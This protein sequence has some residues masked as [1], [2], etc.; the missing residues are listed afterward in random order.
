S[1]APA[2][3]QALDREADFEW[4]R[5][6]G[7]LKWALLEDLG[8]LPDEALRPLVDAGLAAAAAALDE[9]GNWGT[10]HRLHLN[11]IL[12]RAPVIGAR[13]RFADLPAS[14]TQETVMKAA[15]GLFAGRPAAAFY[16]SQ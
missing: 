8:R 3:Y 7:H 9:H 1:L 13:Y 2:F 10:V 14:G 12:S 6:S 4:I 5:D 11:H 15:H 16:G